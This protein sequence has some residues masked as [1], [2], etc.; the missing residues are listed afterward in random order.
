MTAKE[1][2]MCGNVFGTTVII[3]ELRSID[4]SYILFKSI[5]LNLA[6]PG[7]FIHM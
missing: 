5:G 2:N 7:E 6:T 1:I 4:T 3:I